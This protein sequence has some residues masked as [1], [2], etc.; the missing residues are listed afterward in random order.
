MPRRPHR[1]LWLAIALLGILNLLAACG[2]KG[3]LYLPPAE[4]PPAIEQD[5]GQ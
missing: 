1:L 3:P 5:S 2:Q 4:E